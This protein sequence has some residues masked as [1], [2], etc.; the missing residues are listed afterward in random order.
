M[1]Y[2][3]TLEDVTRDFQLTEKQVEALKQFRQNVADVMLPKHDDYVL[4]RFL[5][6]RDFDLSKSED[7]FRKSMQ[8]RKEWKVDTILT[9][10]KVPEV[11]QK[12][13]PGGH[14]GYDKEGCPIWLIRGAK[15]DIKGIVLSVHRDDVTRFFIWLMEKVAKLCDDQTEKLGRK[16]Y[17]M[18]AINDMSGFTLSMVMQPGWDQ[19]MKLFPMIEANYPEFMRVNFIF[20]APRVFPVVFNMVRPFMHEN[21]RKKIRVFGSTN[22]IDSMVEIVGSTDGIPQSMGGTKVDKNGDP[23]CKALVPAGGEVPQ[24]Y[25]LKPEDIIGSNEMEAQTA[26]VGKGAFFDLPFTIEK[27]GTKML[28]WVF[29]TIHYDIKFKVFYQE[30]TEARYA[31]SVR[32]T[33]RINA[34]V[35]PVDGFIKCFKPG[36]YTFRFDNS[37]SWVRSKEVNYIIEL[38]DV[39]KSSHED[40]EMNLTEG[41]DEDFGEEI[42]GLDAEVD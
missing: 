41:P 6:A 21:T 37:Y 24:S 1:G 28:R 14:F 8:W 32:D 13:Y 39:D 4:V 10:W 7:M 9:D 29:W 31:Q 12:Y 5:R 30:N 17:N 15:F 23:E 11:L 16:I 25:Y 42:P 34:Q 19:F 3:P 18:T 26:V 38:V 20:N 35:L 22:Y 2:T 33:E 27:G 40:V 36:I